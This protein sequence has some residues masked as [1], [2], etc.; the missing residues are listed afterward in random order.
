MY[1]GYYANLWIN[2]KYTGI[3]ADTLRE[4]REQLATYGLKAEKNLRFDN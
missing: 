2:D 4:L 3:H 1:G